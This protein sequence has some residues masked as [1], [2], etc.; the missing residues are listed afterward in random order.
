MNRSQRRQTA[1][2]ELP[3]EADCEGRHMVLRRRWVE[4]DR[5][6]MVLRRSQKSGMADASNCS[7]C[8]AGRH[9]E[10]MLE[11]SACGSWE[12]PVSPIRATHNAEALVPR[13]KQMTGD[14]LFTA[15][16]AP[17][18]RPALHLPVHGVWN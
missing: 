9:R 14:L 4:K 16:A 11:G 8:G 17:A 5:K 1:R 13:A 6:H 2:S 18:A 7:M 10:G 15:V 3:G 12:Y